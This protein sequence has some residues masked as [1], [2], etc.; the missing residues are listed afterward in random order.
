MVKNILIDELELDG[1]ILCLD[2][3]NTVSN[4]GD[5]T[6]KDY[7]ANFDDLLYWAV[8]KVEII[9]EKTARL[10][11]KKAQ[12]ESVKAQHFFKEA[13]VLRKL[14]HDIFLQVSNAEQ[15]SAENMAEFN[16]TM[17][18]YN[19]HIQLQQ[20]GDNFKETWDWE[21]DSFFQITAPIIKT[22]YTLLLS[23]KL[24]RVRECC[25]NPC[26]WLFLDTSKN[27]KR[28]WCSMDTC[29]SNDKAIKYYY[30]QK[31]QKK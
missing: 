23:D 5:A 13:M 3:T 15:V 24:G 26:G 2:F 9:T 1:G 6:E 14:I 19:P 12:A 17:K 30:R 18:M 28:R 8:K 22:A 11:D 25:S 7:L 31:E 16:E 29:G 4:R 10:I 21:P 20:N 27:G